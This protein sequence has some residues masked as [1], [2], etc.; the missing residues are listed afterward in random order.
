MLHPLDIARRIVPPRWKRALKRS[1]GMPLTRLHEDWTILAPIGPVEERHVVI[2]GGSNEGWFF[3][4]WKDW[5]PSAVVHAFEPSAEACDVSRRLYGSDP[6]V[7]VVNAGLGSVRG[8]LPLRV[9]GDIPTGHSFLPHA[10]ERWRELEYEPGA[11]TS[12]AV[13]VTTL[14]DYANENH[15]DEIY[16]LKLRVQ[17]FELEVLR[18]AAAILPRTR[19]VFVGAGIRPLYDGAPDFCEVHAYLERAGFHL[20]AIRTWHRG[21]LTL[22]EALMLFRRNDLMPPIEGDVDR[23]YT[24][25]GT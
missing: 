10:P 12:R 3:H 5:C 1:L 21:N 8:E 2:D 18:G 7:H 14:D 11:I 24:T 15:I 19:Y 9:M 4:C 17:G 6:D 23:I 25:A 20:I 22:V 16:L 13:P